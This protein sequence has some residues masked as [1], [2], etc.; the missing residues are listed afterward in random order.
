VKV[1]R[2]ILSLLVL[3]AL[4][5]PAQSQ[6][7]TK[8]RVAA[9][10]LENS[11]QAFYAKEMGFFTKEGLDVEL[12]SIQSG[13]AVAAAIAGNAADIG[14]AS[15]IPLALAHKKNIPFVLIAPGA[16][17]TQ[18]A[19]NDAL[20]VA[21]NSTIRS[22]KD[23]NG[24][25]LTCAG[26]GTLTEYATRL[27]IDKNGG[28]ASSVKFVEMGYSSMPVALAAG[29]IDAALVNEPY[30]GMVKKDGRLLGYAFDAL[31]KEYMIGGW[32]SNAQWAK[33]H[34]DL[35][36][37]FAA[38]MHDAA[39]WAN[40]PKNSDKA[41]EILESTMKLDPALAAGMIHVR[42]GTALSTAA[43]QPQ[44]DLAAKYGG[45]TT[46]PASEIIYTASR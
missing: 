11:A 20:F 10:P 38:A 43:V 31:G 40:D 6:G 35:V 16:F 33:D 30:L 23:L 37:R 39:M 29:R 2:L 42:F 14:F 34:P 44:I 13:S 26:L 22:A 3:V 15:I 19:R 12:T 36:K 25:T 45:F 28:D 41:T 46:F 8:V 24:K 7:L 18:A 32:F 17:W 9:I 27:W 4:S 1:L 5:V 21:S